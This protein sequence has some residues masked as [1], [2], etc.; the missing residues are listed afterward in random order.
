MV[1]LL[2]PSVFGKFGI[3]NATLMSFSIVATLGMGM[4]AT[5]LVAQFRTADP[6]EAGRVIS[7]ATLIAWVAGGT[8][9]L[10][11][12][13]TATFVAKNVLGAPELAP[14][15]RCMALALFF[16]SWG[17]AQSGVLTG[18]EAFSLMARLGIV[19]AIVSAGLTVLGAWLWGL[20][21]AVLAVPAAGLA[22]CL[23]QEWL[24]RIALKRHGIALFINQMLV[25]IRLV[26]R[27]GV[28]VMLSAALV[29]PAS[30]ACST[31]LVNQPD[32][33][34]Q[35]A[36]VTIGEQ[37]FNLV[38]TLPAILGQVLVPVLSNIFSDGDQNASKLV[39][40]KVFWINAGVSVLPLLLLLPASPHL[41]AL[42]GPGYAQHWPIIS[43]LLLSGGV[44][45]VVSPAGHALTATGRMWVA[46]AM[47]LG[48]ALVYIAATYILVVRLQRGANGLALAR[49][50][51]YGFHAVWS[52]W[53]L[54]SAMRR[55]GG[56]LVVQV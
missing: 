39:L 41:M 42:Y 21:G 17:S 36:L 4:A 52:L 28:P 19:F 26:L 46:F 37:W 50:I 6:V 3:I 10:A 43:L 53:Y 24:M 11:T 51:A 5:K 20:R 18:I 23:A 7:S 55:D 34:R 25:R 22:Q 54:R 38:L 13:L 14:E 9:A 35:N 1:R 47:N 15:L 30:W 40:R 12:L 56:A 33:Y 44:A 27:L 29:L 16:V 49:L 48:W 8:M 45:C 2:E 32:G 31:L